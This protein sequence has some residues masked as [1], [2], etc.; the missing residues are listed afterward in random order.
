[1]RAGSQQVIEEQ[2]YPSKFHVVHLTFHLAD[3][4]VAAEVG[5]ETVVTNGTL[6][7]TE[8]RHSLLLLGMCE[9]KDS[10]EQ[11]RSVQRTKRYTLSHSA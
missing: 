7:K 8:E 1:M 9:T 6:G 4:A 5:S 2:L 10:L 3:D 11:S